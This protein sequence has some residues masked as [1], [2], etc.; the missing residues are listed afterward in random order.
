M[1]GKLENKMVTLVNVYA[2]PNSGK[3]FF[4]T[5]FDTMILEGILICGGDFSIVLTS[6]LDPTNKNKKATHVTKMI[7]AFKEFGI[8]DTWRELHPSERLYTL[9]SPK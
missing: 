7:K 6:N 4:K 1:K 5:L 8:I 2:P 3:Q 9:L